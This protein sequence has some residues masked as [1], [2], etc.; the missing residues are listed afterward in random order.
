MISSLLL[1]N[2]IHLFSLMFV[3]LIYSVLPALLNSIP[4]LC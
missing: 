2:S 1:S 3:L 4:L